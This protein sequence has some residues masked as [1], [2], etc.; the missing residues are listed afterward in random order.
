MTEANSLL[1]LFSHVQ[2]SPLC[3]WK[4]PSFFASFLR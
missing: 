2:V 3:K 1:P 4:M